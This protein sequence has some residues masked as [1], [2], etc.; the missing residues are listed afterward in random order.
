MS[1]NRGLGSSMKQQ[2]IAEIVD[3][4][5]LRIATHPLKRRT[6]KQFRDCNGSV[7]H[8]EH[9]H[10]PHL[11]APGFPP[12]TLQPAHISLVRR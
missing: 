12:H 9:P 3:V 6:Q 10:S 11:V 2:L 4:Y 8:F 7:F 1:T 5:Q